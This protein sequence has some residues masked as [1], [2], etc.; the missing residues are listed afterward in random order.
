MKL[1]SVLGLVLGAAI[2]TTAVADAHAADLKVHGSGTVNKGILLPNQ[3]AIEGEI[4]YT[5]AIVANGSGAGLKD[6]A[7]GKADVAV[8]SAPLAVEAALTNAKAPGSLDI[9]GMEEHEIGSKTINFIINPKN[10]VGSLSDAQLKDIFTGKVTNWSEVGGP[11]QPIIVA[12]E[13]PGNGTRAVVTSVF[14]G[15]ADYSGG[16][17]EFR[18]LTQ[19]AQ[20]VGQAPNAIGYGNSSSITDAIKVVDGVDVKQPLA[21]VTK[22]APTGDHQKLIDAAKKFSGS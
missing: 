1:G 2:V 8:I 18:A 4:G 14:L 19:V 7:S 3:T 16:A 15:G 13:T 11:S 6:L 12:V 17:K 10:P 21:V 20:I 22:G 9:T 5:L